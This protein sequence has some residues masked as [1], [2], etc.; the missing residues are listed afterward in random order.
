MSTTAGA[1]P[2]ALALTG[3]V[4]SMARQKKMS[5]H[6]KITQDGRPNGKKYK[7]HP[8]GF[9]SEKRKLECTNCN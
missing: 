2:G 1:P 9:N 3:R 6:K 4:S 7:L 5:V 8:L